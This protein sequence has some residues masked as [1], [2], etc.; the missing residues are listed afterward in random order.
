VESDNP[1]IVIGR[2]GRPHGIK[3]FVTILSFTEPRDN[4]VGYT[5]W[6]VRLN[7][8]L[9]PLTLENLEMGQKFIVTQVAG[10][11]SREDVA[12]LTNLDILIKRT[13]LPPLKKGDYYWHQLEGMRVV[14]QQGIFLGCVLEVMATGANDVLVVVGEKRYLIP[15]LPGR[16]IINV[17]DQ[18][19]VITVD[20]DTDF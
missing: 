6:H 9:Q 10:Y 1:W 20:W 15:Y 8:Q 13:Q 12:R 19:Q 18:Q 16:S 5:D 11:P 3:G 7:H 17:D 2:F 14:S 4:M